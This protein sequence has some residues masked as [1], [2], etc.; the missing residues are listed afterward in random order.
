M[1]RASVVLGCLVLVGACTALPGADPSGDAGARRPG[2][3]AD[4]GRAGASDGGVAGIGD[5]SA[6][7]DDPDHDGYGLGCPLGEVDCNSNDPAVHPGA[8]E[9]CGD[10]IDNDCDGHVDEDE[11]CCDPAVTD[12][13]RG[14]DPAQT[15][16]SFVFGLSKSFLGLDPLCGTQRGASLDTRRDLIVGGIDRIV[17][18]QAALSLGDVARTA[19]RPLLESGDLETTLLALTDVVA[20]LVDDAFDPQR[21]NLTAMAGVLRTDTVLESEQLFTLARG[22]LAGDQAPRAL[23]ALAQIAQELDGAEPAI[24]ALMRVLSTAL[25]AQ[26]HVAQCTGLDLQPLVERLLD[27]TGMPA[28]PELGAAAPVASAAHPGTTF[29]AKRTG[30]GFAFELAGPAL[31]AGL[32]RDAL[33]FADAALGAQVSCGTQCWSY[34]GADSPLADVLHLGLELLRHDELKAL[35]GGVARLVHERPD[36][37]EKLAIATGKL[38]TRVRQAS[39]RLDTA[40]LARLARRLLPLVQHIFAQGSDTPRLLIRTINGLGQTARDF[41]GRLRWTLDYS[42]LVKARSCSDSEPDFARSTPVN[43]S[44]PRGVANRSSLEQVLELLSSSDCGSVPLTGGKT[45]A[46]FFLDLVADRT[47]ATVCSVVDVLLG[48]WSATG[49]VGDFFVELALRTAGCRDPHAVLDNLGSLDQLAGSGALDFLIPLDKIISGQ[50]QTRTIIAIA[51]VIA[52][53]LRLDNDSDPA[54]Q[55]VFRPLLPVL[56]DLIASGAVDALFDLSEVMTQ[57]Q[58]ADAHGQTATLADVL[59]DATAFMLVDRELTTRQ[60]AARRSSFAA[61]LLDPMIVLVDRVSGVATSGAGGRILDHLVGYL[62]ADGQGHLAHRGVLPLTQV[63]LDGLVAVWRLEPSSRDCYVAALQADAGDVLTSPAFAT[64]VRLGRI[65][66]R[67]PQRAAVEQALVAWLQPVPVD[68]A[69]SV[70]SPL[71]QVTAALLQMHPPV[72]AMDQLVAFAGVALDPARVNGVAVLRTFDTLLE[73]DRDQV[74][75]GMFR[76]AV[77][78]SPAGPVPLSGLVDGYGPALSISPSACTPQN[79]PWTARGLDTALGSLVRMLRDPRYGIPAVF[80][81]LE[82]LLAGP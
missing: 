74:F 7:C 59:I 38:V 78:P 55:S 80:D 1:T 66:D 23:H 28:R 29:D 77:A 33:A 82:A 71:L 24:S 70:F 57:V 39:L 16:G 9:V 41:P 48:A 67:S 21:T 35:L 30:L 49:V 73:A 18:E 69:A 63:L 68:P 72:G 15:I 8:M 46:Q 31:Q 27:P 81:A 19:L 79:A 4:G 47:P 42:N 14:P 5:A 65:L 20:L 62:Q 12:C 60:G 52:E 61:A 43:Y 75:L 32:H 36:V 17:S 56:S 45:V 40:Q 50:G 10:G 26:S 13:N 22:V 6:G 58:T 3:P 53:D 34:P 51:G 37:A 2:K 64:L 25:K 11:D 54:T 44:Q 76:R